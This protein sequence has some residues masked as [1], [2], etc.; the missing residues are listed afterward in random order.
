LQNR[1][2]LRVIQIGERFRKLLLGLRVQSVQAAAVELLPVGGRYADQEIE[3]TRA[4]RNPTRRIAFQRRLDESA[5]AVQ[6]REL[7]AVKK[8]A[9]GS[10]TESG[11]VTS[12]IAGPLPGPDP[13]RPARTGGAAC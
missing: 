2:R 11:G 9:T 4:R 13:P 6:S 8:R 10:A 1:V 5:Q 7:R 12:S 3:E